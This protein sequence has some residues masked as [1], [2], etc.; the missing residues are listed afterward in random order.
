MEG[1]I[2][3]QTE[4]DFTSLKFNQLTIHGD[5]SHSAYASSPHVTLLLTLFASCPFS[6]LQ[7]YVYGNITRVDVSPNPVDGGDEPTITFFGFVNNSSATIYRGKLEVYIY[8]HYL[9]VDTSRML[10]TKRVDENDG[11]IERGKNFKLSIR[12][13]A[14]EANEGEAPISV[15]LID[16]RPIYDDKPVPQKRLCFDMYLPS[17]NHPEPSTSS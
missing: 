6:I 3:A 13:P 8:S 4:K 17:T 5:I 7:K 16:E 11:I 12:L 2:I 1:S 9:H 10:V 15:T 14:S